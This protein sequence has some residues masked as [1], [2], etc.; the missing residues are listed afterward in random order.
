MKYGI[1][2]TGPA[3]GD[4]QGQPRGGSRLSPW[5]PGAYIYIYI[6]IYISYTFRVRVNDRLRL[7]FGLELRLRLRHVEVRNPPPPNPPSP[8]PSPSSTIPSPDVFFWCVCVPSLP[9]TLIHFLF[10]ALTLYFFSF[11]SLFFPRVFFLSR[12]FCFLSRVFLLLSR[13]P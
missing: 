8:S 12:V 13:T 6:Y 11:F 4:E 7:R 3:P 1:V 9:P 2:W 5:N 10:H